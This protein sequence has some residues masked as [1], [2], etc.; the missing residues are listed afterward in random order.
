MIKI[1]IDKDVLEKYKDFYFEKYPKRRVFP[2][3]KIIPPSFNY[4][5]SMK[6]IVQNSL[7]QQYKEFSVWLANYYNIA[8]LNLNKAKITYTFFFKDRRRRDFD[9]LLLTPKLIN[10]GF[11][12]ANVLVDDN[13]ENLKI[14]FEHFQYDKNNPRVE[15][16]IEEQRND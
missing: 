10:D 2:I 13:G 11:V 4:F 12:T 6:R 16:K 14:E 9:N 1:V 7:K 3:K 8:D 15:M 5:T